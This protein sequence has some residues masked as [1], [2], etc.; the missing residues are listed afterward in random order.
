MAH[1]L[2]VTMLPQPADSACGPTCLHAVYRH[3]GDEVELPHDDSRSRLAPQR[4]AR[5]DPKLCE[6][7]QASLDD[8][9]VLEP[10]AGAPPKDAP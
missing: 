6:A 4:A 5:T 1:R 9:L 3:H 8:L 7:T 10:P 2:S